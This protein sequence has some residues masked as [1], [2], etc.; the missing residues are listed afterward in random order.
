VLMTPPRPGE[1]FDGE[2][3]RLGAYASRLWL[4]MLH[5]EKDPD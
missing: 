5:A 3:T 2:T 4:P 1:E